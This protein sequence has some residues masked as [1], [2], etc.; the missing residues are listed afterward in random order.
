MR[1]KSVNMFPKKCCGNCVHYNL[2]GD[3]ACH[4]KESSF[5]ERVTCP[6]EEAR[7]CNVFKLRASWQILRESLS[8]VS[9]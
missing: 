8:C 6:L 3:F 9:G 5:Y 1:D 2:Y 7:L 4:N